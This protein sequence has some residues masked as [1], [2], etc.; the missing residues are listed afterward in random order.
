MLIWV[1]TED[2]NHTVMTITKMI[3]RLVTEVA[4][5]AMWRLQVLI[6]IMRMIMMITTIRTIS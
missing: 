6:G 2:A 4:M 5:M 3:I 1:D